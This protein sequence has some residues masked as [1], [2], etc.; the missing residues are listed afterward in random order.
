MKKKS[1]Q[2][3]T[4][5]ISGMAVINYIAI[6]V[7]L[8]LPSLCDAQTTTLVVSGQTNPRTMFVYGPANLP[9]NPRLVISLHGLGNVI[10]D[11]RKGSQWELVADTAKFV[12]VFPQGEGNSWDINGNK[13][14]D[15][16]SAIIESMVKRYNIDR[17]RVYVTGFSMGGMMSYHVANKLANKVAAI[18]PVSG[19]LFS[20]VV[21][22]SRPMP[23]IHIHGSADNVVYYQP[24]GNQQGVVAMLQ[25]WRSWD[26]CP[27]NG[28][29]VTPYPVNI[30][31]SKSVMEHWGP[32]NNSEVQLI[33]IDNKYHV[34]SNDPNGVHTTNELWKFFNKQALTTITSNLDEERFEAPTV[35]PNPFK[36]VFSINMKGYFSYQLLSVSGKLLSEGQG[37]NLIEISGQYPD[38]L[39]YLKI[40]QE[41]KIRIVKVIKL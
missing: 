25:K 10:D 30:P 12:V 23:I 24:S 6:A 15:F 32:C 40:Q 18:G 34:N 26:K 27:A 36:D 5:I 33:T 19:Y 8:M 13:D 20:N 3:L 11:Q 7:I 21:A 37:E 28:T 38:G 35:F 22:S 41:D 29:R 14:I 1:T 17:N 31:N 9:S 4:G 16:I 2:Y 39:Y